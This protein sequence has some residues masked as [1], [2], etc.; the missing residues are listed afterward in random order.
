MGSGGDGCVVKEWWVEVENDGA[1]MEGEG[2][3]KS[4]VFFS[5]SKV[6]RMIVDMMR[7]PLKTR[8]RK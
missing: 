8:C 2:R 4:L 5:Y 7:L 1:M 3:Q 6:R